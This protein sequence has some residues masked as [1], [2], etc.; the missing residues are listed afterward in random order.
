MEEKGSVVESMTAVI[1][2]VDEFYVC[3]AGPYVDIVFALWSRKI[4]LCSGS[5]KSPTSLTF[6]VNGRAGKQTTK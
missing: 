1:N 6:T 2:V 5:F 3:F 4:I